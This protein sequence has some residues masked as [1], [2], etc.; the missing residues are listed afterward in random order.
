MR[1]K[2]V[3]NFPENW[4]SVILHSQ[5]LQLQA[6]N[7]LNYFQGASKFLLPDSLPK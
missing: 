4:M 3:N 1:P 5:I 7:Y 2:S 6:R